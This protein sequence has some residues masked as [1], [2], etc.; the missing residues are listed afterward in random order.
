MLLKPGM[1]P[2]CQMTGVSKIQLGDFGSF[3]IAPLT[4]E[5]LRLKLEVA[6]PATASL[7]VTV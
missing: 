1:P 6:R 7:K 3:T 5:R 4:P 2:L